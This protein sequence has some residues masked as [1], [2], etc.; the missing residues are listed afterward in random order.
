MQ[1]F[2]QLTFDSDSETLSLTISASAVD[3]V[4]ETILT[5]E[6][7]IPLITVLLSPL[8]FPQKSKTN[9]KNAVFMKNLCRRKNKMNE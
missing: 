1:K 7:R 2:C 8:F 6:D 5:P 4:K 3:S 9:L